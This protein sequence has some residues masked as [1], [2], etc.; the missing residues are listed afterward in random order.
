MLWGFGPDQ[1]M[2]QIHSVMT[3]LLNPNQQTQWQ[4]TARYRTDLSG[5]SSVEKQIK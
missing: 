1:F 2:E 3:Q 4:E 5:G